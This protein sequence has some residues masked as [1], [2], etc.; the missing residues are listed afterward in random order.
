MQYTAGL[1]NVSLEVSFL[2]AK[3]VSSNGPHGVKTRYHG[4]R[5]KTCE[6]KNTLI[7]LSKRIWTYF[8]EYGIVRVLSCSDLDLN[9]GLLA[10]GQ[11]SKV[12]FDAM[13][14]MNGFCTPLRRV[15]CCGYPPKTPSVKGLSLLRWRYVSVGLP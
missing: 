5:R 10:L 11:V 1:T 15:L 12:N 4:G 7:L 13:G 6:R 14:G 3:F 9:R 8:G 2:D